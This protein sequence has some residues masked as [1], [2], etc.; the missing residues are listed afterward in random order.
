MAVADDHIIGLGSRLPPWGAL[1]FPPAGPNHGSIKDVKIRQSTFGTQTAG[2][3][4]GC[5]R[6]PRQLQHRLLSC[7]NDPDALGPGSC[8]E[9]PS[10]S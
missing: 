10:D 7:I 1:L 4:I 5:A 8:S 9:R 6:D 3:Q 2:T